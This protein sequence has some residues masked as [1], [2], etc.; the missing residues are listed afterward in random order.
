MEQLYE[1]GMT[2][3]G[4]IYA[5]DEGKGFIVVVFACRGGADSLYFTKD[6]RE[7]KDKIGLRDPE[8][9]EPLDFELHEGDVLIDL[10]TKYEE[11]GMTRLREMMEE[12]GFYMDDKFFI[13][14][15]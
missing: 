7:A 13:R 10:M 12:Q 2:E 1:M 11:L 3:D 6:V 4:C 9:D 15:K 14:K 5:M 8:K